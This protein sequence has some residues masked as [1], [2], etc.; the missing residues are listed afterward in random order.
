MEKN[1]FS[2][3][4]KHLMSVAEVKNY[5]LAREL[6]Y[7][8]SYISKWTSGQLLPTEK[9]EE[10]ILKEISRCIVFSC[11][12]GALEKLMTDYQVEN[13]EALCMAI[14][15]NLEAEYFYVRDLQNNMGRDVAPKTFFFPELSMPQYIA[16]MRH[17]VLRRV[18]SLEIAGALDLFSMKREYLARILG[19]EKE[20]IPSGR[21]YPDVHYSLLINIR[22]DKWDYT[23]DTV[24]LIHLLIENQCVDFRLYGS[25]Q[26]V[27][28]AVFVVKNE[29]SISGMLFGSERCM[30]V[31]ISEDADTCSEMY[32]NIMALC[33]KERLLFRKTT[34]KELL[35]GH[36]YL[37]GL[38]SMNSRW[39]IG[40]LTEHFLPDDL[41]EELAADL[42]AHQ[43][44][45]LNIDVLRETHQVTKRIIE[46]SKIRL[47]INK[48][49]FYNLVVEQELD[50]YNYRIH[51]SAG[52]QVRCLQYFLELCRNHGNLE[53]KLISGKLLEDERYDV[54][55]CVFLSDSAACLRLT[56]NYN[57]L[58]VINR[59]DME[60]I[61]E[62]TFD[63][64]WNTSNKGIV[65]DQAAIMEHIRHVIRGIYWSNPDLKM[66]DI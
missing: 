20:H 22:K 1:R 36:E 62:K 39:V 32:K 40:H 48:N 11:G 65:E 34:M 53:M 52:Q 23:Y 58:F 47:L 44:N 42:G 35:S 46:E 66:A 60:E 59:S 6:Q 26:A 27:G 63:K 18:S 17:P 14:F 30:S 10:K 54:S 28:K 50:F 21:G 9:L 7:D 2:R 12:N 56:E 24:F 37:R 41:F 29:Y 31:V 49:A 19:S 16:K 55:P 61:F 43:D 3:L 25:T 51:L 64:F 57:N 13:K 33:S 15:D 8:V 5:T 4:L 45:E 38:L